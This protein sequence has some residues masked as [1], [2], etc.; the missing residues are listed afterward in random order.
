MAIGSPGVLDQGI[1]FHPKIH[2]TGVD[3]AKSIFLEFFVAVLS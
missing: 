3:I 2:K 1:Q